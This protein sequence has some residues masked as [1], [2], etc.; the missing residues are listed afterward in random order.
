[1]RAKTRII[2][3]FC[4]LCL[5]T[6]V[7]AQLPT[8]QQPSREFLLRAGDL[9]SFRRYDLAAD[10]YVRLCEVNPEDMTAYSGARRCLL[11]LQQYVRLEQLALRLQKSHR[12][13]QF[14]ADLAEIAY[15]Q[16]QA[17]EAVR[18]WMN[19]VDNNPLS[20]EAYALVGATL[21]GYGLWE[22]ALSVYQQARRRL[23]ASVQFAL[24]I[25]RILHQQGRYEQSALELCTYLVEFPDQFGVV[26]S[27]FINYQN[28]PSSFRPT[29]KCLEKQI[30]NTPQLAL[31][32]RQILG[33]IYTQTRK[34]EEALQQY[35]LLETA[36]K[37][38]ENRPVP[39]HF[40]YQLGMTALQDSA[41]APA[42]LA[43]GLLIEKFANSPYSRR[44]EL[45]LAEIFEQQHEYS[46]AIS[47]FEKFAARHEKSQETLAALSR[48]GDIQLYQSFDLMGAEKTFKQ[49]LA[50]YGRSQYQYTGMYRLGEI[51]LAAGNLKEASDYFS[52]IIRETA[53]SLETHRL[54]LWALAQMDFYAGRP[55]SA[56]K[57]LER[58][59]SLKSASEP[60]KVENDVLELY[61][62]LT[63]N[64]GDSIGL[65][66]LG[67][68]RLSL[69]Q[70]HYEQAI[71]QFQSVTG[72]LENEAKFNILEVYRLSGRPI[73][74]LP[75]CEALLQDERCH[76]A[77][78]VLMIQ[79]EIYERDI[80]DLN[81]AQKKYETLLEK[82]PQSIYI[83]T[84]RNRVRELDK[85]LLKERL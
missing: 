27:Q 72:A 49:I 80:K 37:S 3:V 69:R 77:D 54:A 42:R 13:I 33:A 78:R 29:V 30:K 25:S 11:Q 18:R 44:A 45:S 83:E 31:L 41:Y 17:D 43:F 36:E 5:S 76:Q 8:N 12:H 35:L 75:I 26:Q 32:G 81:Q 46:K 62:L 63:T 60:N 82:Y 1:L 14:E 74:A 10:I 38:K 56:E 23:K 65:A 85:Q 6:A 51:A 21:E 59:L 7:W 50:E 53:E 9:E 64:H 84:A 68:G 20:E 15:L 19:I 73:M 4:Y 48:I 61:F 66:R 24:E 79:A 16:G 55:S 70:R 71:K 39:G 52:T 67:E 58:A 57:R 28:E 34:Y 47:A 2:N 40:L 22:E